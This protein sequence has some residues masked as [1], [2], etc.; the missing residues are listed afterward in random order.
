MADSR[1]VTGSIT[2]P[3]RGKGPADEKNAGRPRRGRWDKGNFVFNSEEDEARWRRDAYRQSVSHDGWQRQNPVDDQLQATFDSMP[4]LAEGRYFRGADDRY[5]PIGREQREAPEVERIR[6]RAFTELANTG[7]TWEELGAYEPDKSHPGEDEAISLVQSNAMTG[8][9]GE[10]SV[11]PDK[12]RDMGALPEGPSNDL[13]PDENLDLDAEQIAQVWGMA[14]SKDSLPPVLLASNGKS[15]P[16]G[17]LKGLVTPPAFSHRGRPTPT[18][19]RRYQFNRTLAVRRARD[20]TTKQTPQTVQSP[21]PAVSSRTSISSSPKSQPDRIT[22]VSTGSAGHVVTDPEFAIANPLFNWR[23]DGGQPP[24]PAEFAVYAASDEGRFTYLEDRK[25]EWSRQLTSDPDYVFRSMTSEVDKLSVAAQ[26]DFLTSYHRPA[27]AAEVAEINDA[28]ERI[29]F[30]P[31]ER[32]SDGKRHLGGAPEAKEYLGIEEPEV[33]SGDDLVSALERVGSVLAQEEIEKSGGRPGS[34]ESRKAA[35]LIAEKLAAAIKACGGKVKVELYGAREPQVQYVAGTVRGSRYPDTAVPYEYNGKTVAPM[36]SH[37]ST[38][39]DGVTMSTREANQWSGL[40]INLARA[41]YQ[42]DLGIDAVG[43]GTIP[44]KGKNQTDA[45]YE[46]M[47]DDLV[48]KM[49]D[50]RR[51][52]LIKLDIDPL[53]VANEDLPEPS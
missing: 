46:K 51:P 18:Y 3:I 19:Q 45:D 30:A 53:D 38:K 32:W 15:V 52:F 20:L 33:H 27:N 14:T 43:L 2:A 8:S 36:I 40:S 5:R 9:A 17:L 11:S 37:Y 26:N 29:V 4:E 39:A 13:N 34:V 31:A 24:A 23:R 22:N 12:I 44:K 10:K 25:D 48:K 49:I 47:I 6:R 28:V 41:I 35:R 16:S 42:G 21:A 1:H 50:C 7:I